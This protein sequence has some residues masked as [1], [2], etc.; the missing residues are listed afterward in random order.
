MGS[1]AERLAASIF[2]PNYPQEQTSSMRSG[3]S[4]LC[5]KLPYAVQQRKLYSITSS[6]RASRVRGMAR[7]SALA[8]ARLMTKSSL[9]RK[10]M[11]RSPAWAP[12]KTQIK[13][14]HFARRFWGIG[15]LMH[16]SCTALPCP[17]SRETSM[18][19]SGQSRSL[20]DVPAM[21]GLPPVS[22]RSCVIA[23]GLRSAIDRDRGEPRGSAPPTPPYVRVRIRR[24]EKL[25]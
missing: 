23:V 16:L 3:T 24:F 1:K 11:G 15:T 10:S 17:W 20:G 2:H 14:Y 9:V 12:L 5:H 13:T 25:S 6:A 22:G 7:P 4:D 18:S 8:V 21:S 19:K